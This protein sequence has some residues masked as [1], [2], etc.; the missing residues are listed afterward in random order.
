MRVWVGRLEGRATCL[1]PGLSLWVQI[2]HRA[3]LGRPSAYFRVCSFPSQSVSQA[4]TASNF[5][6][7]EFCAIAAP[8][9]SPKGYERAINDVRHRASKVCGLATSV[10]IFGL[11]GVREGG[12]RRGNTPL[13][14]Y[15]I[16]K[17][18]K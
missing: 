11:A 9:K 1:R 7:R 8:K 6:P 12:G 14:A 10:S 3:Q 13:L 4:Q 15:H 2:P 16:R 17:L 18:W 5:P